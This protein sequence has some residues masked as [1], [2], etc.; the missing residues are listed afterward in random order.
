MSFMV[1]RKYKIGNTVSIY[2]D[3]IEE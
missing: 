1:I 3:V 2:T